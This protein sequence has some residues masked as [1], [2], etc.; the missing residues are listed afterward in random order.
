MLGY[1]HNTAKLWYLWDPIQ[2]SAINAMNIRFDED[3]NTAARKLSEGK[4]LSKLTMDTTILLQPKAK[5]Q[6]RREIIIGDAQPVSTNAP[7]QQP[8]SNTIKEIEID[9]I[10]NASIQGEHAGPGIEDIIVVKPLSP[11]S[12]S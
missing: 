2:K 5:C 6:L 8:V 3:N 12:S 4:V 11:K 1:I 9:N 7:E 10:D